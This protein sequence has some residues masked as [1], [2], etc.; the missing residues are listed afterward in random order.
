M[1][2]AAA[3]EPTGVA[4]TF[5]TVGGESNKKVKELK[6]VFLDQVKFPSNMNDLFRNHFSHILSQ[7]IQPVHARL[8]ALEQ[9]LEQLKTRFIGVRAFNE[10]VN[11]DIDSLN[12]EVANISV[13]FEDY[14]KISF[15]VERL[16]MLETLMTDRCS[17]LMTEIARSRQPD[18]PRVGDTDRADL[19]RGADRGRQPERTVANRSRSPS[20]ELYVPVFRHGRPDEM[21]PRRLVLEMME[22]G[23]VKP[24]DGHPAFEIVQMMAGFPPDNP[25]TSPAGFRL[26][27]LQSE[28]GSR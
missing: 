12:T 8:L 16:N 25:Q 7:I 19:G 5:P 17:L 24:R 22:H 21:L 10:E 15:V 11:S 26:Q 13:A 9:E 20:G 23:F 6:K 4:A 14:A 28:G 1:A 18:V 3:D 2:A 27:R